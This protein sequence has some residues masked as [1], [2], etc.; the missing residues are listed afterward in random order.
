MSTTGC[1]FG[2]AWDGCVNPSH[3]LQ[4]W[5]SRLVFTYLGSSSSGWGFE[6][7]RVRALVRPSYCTICKSSRTLRPRACA[8][9]TPPGP[10]PLQVGAMVRKREC[11]VQIAREYRIVQQRRGP[12]ETRVGRPE[13]FRTGTTPPSRAHQRR[14]YSFIPQKQ[15]TRASDPIVHSS[16]NAAKSSTALPPHHHLHR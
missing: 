1:C 2:L 13:R 11:E 3:L 16:P 7:G 5:S 9:P 6:H 14:R 15:A 12:T 4:R 8:L 10:P